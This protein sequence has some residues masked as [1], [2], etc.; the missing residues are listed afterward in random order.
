[1]SRKYQFILILKKELSS[2]KKITKQKLI[3]ERQKLR[4]IQ[5]NFYRNYIPIV[6]RKIKLFIQI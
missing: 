4:I 5:N 1:M 6:K 3:I 2:L